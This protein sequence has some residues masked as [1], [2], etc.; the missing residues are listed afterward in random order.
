MKKN[1]FTALLFFVWCLGHAQVSFTAKSGDNELDLH[2]SDMNVQASADIK[3]FNTDL[4]ITYGVP[5]KKIEDLQVSIGMQPADVFMTLE[6]AAL[7]NQPLDNVV[8]NY[9]KNKGKGWGVIAKEMGIKPGSK[10]FHALKG[11]AK[12]KKGKGGK[13]GGKPENSGGGKGKGKGKK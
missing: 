9:K 2:L 5:V 13:G 4:S 3:V 6:I 1:L 11:K 12:D 7:T 8:N 10:E